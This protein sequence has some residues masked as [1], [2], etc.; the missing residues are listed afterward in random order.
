MV[1]VRPVAVLL[2]PETPPSLVGALS[3]LKHPPPIITTLFDPIRLEVLRACASLPC[4]P[5]Y[6]SD[7][8]YVYIAL[9]A[10][11]LLYHTFAL[12]SLPYPYCTKEHY[13]WN[14]SF[15]SLLTWID[16]HHIKRTLHLCAT[17]KSPVFVPVWS[18][19]HFKILRFV[20]TTLYTHAE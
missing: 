15:G 13:I 16:L 4:F 3:F 11:T 10:S 2:C 19:S 20:N 12:S 9:Q 8:P 5:L 7:S 18:I 1:D 17:Y 14:I 6:I